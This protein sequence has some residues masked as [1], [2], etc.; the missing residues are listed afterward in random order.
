MASLSQRGD[1]IFA[2]E[3]G[4]PIFDAREGFR[5][6]LEEAGVASDAEGIRY[7]IYCLRHTYITFRLMYGKGL[8]VYH[9]ANNCGTSVAMIEQYYSHARADSFVDELSI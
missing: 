6:V 3:Y 9:L 1:Y 5:N 4:T 7:T 2:D 8:S